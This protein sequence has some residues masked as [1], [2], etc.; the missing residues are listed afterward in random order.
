MARPAGSQTFALTE[1]PQ[2]RIRAA[3]AYRFRPPSSRLL[4]VALSC[5]AHSRVS[6]AHESYVRCSVRT[7]GHPSACC[8]TCGSALMTRSTITSPKLNATRS[9]SCD[10]GWT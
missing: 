6:V 1:K 2:S 4:K 3:V 8:G 5:D 7:T 10:N 9:S